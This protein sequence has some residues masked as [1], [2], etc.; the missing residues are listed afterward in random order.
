M[1]NINIIMVY[2][3]FFNYTKTKIG[4]IILWVTSHP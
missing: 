2:S 4:T 1:L 3:G